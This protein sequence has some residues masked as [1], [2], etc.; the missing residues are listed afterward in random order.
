MKHLI[1]VSQRTVHNISSRVDWNNLLKTATPGALFRRSW[2]VIG[3]CTPPVVEADAAA[4]AA[5]ALR[6][7]Y[8]IL[9]VVLLL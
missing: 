2:E 4:Q 3:Y 6:F 8:P 9:A 1:D 5:I 7:P